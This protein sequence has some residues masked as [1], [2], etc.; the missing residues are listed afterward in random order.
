V[1]AGSAAGP[2]TADRRWATKSGSESQPDGP[3]AGSSPTATELFTIGHSNVAADKLIG[4]LRQHQIE[5]LVDVRSVP[6]SRHNPQFNHKR[7]AGA[8]AA[9]GIDYTYAGEQLGGR[10]ADPACYEDGK[11]QYDRVAAQS[12]FQEALER[13][14][15]LAGRQR[16]AIMCAEEDPRHCHRHHLIAQS[17]LRRGVVVRHI[18]GD[19]RLEEAQMDA[20]MPRQPPLL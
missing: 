6:Y 1:A 19:G 14:I 9:A 8:V 5:V 13:L 18:R 4:L 3:A 20:P 16:I 2:S 7:I 11:V 12:G 15:A 17:L 10:P